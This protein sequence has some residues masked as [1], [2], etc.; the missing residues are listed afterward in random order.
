VIITTSA[1]SNCVVS[2]T[3]NKTSVKLR[4]SEGA[5]DAVGED[6]EEA[7]F[8]HSGDKEEIRSD[9][10][11]GL[12]AGDLISLIL[13]SLMEMESNHEARIQYTYQGFLEGFEF[14]D[15]SFNLL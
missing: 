3:N 6:G 7:E 5:N 12:H 1:K 8:K 9:Q 14:D 15:L 4:A 11:G 13:I 10:F 2:P